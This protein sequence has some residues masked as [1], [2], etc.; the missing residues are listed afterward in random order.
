MEQEIEDLKSNIKEKE[1]LIDTLNTTISE[2][3]DQIKEL[4]EVIW[5]IKEMC[6]KT[7]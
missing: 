1:G 7:L 3:E 6:L 5:D 4:E 2:N